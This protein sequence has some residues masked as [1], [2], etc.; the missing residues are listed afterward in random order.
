MGFFDF[1]FG[2]KKSKVTVEFH[3]NIARSEQKPTKKVDTTTQDLVLLCVAEEYRINETKY[4]DSLRTRFG[5]GF[6]KEKFQQL[7]NNGYL[8]VST[9]VET[10]PCLKATE[11]KAIAT[12][13]GV[14]TSGKK[15][16]ICARIAEN[17][18]EDVLQSEIIERYWILTE[19]GKLYLEEHA[20]IR[21][22]MEKHPYSLENIGLDINAYSKLFSGNPIGQVRD[23]LW[24][25]FN[26]LSEK[27]FIEG[28]NQKSF[29]N[30]CDLLRTMALFLEEENRHKD[31]LAMYIRYLHYRAN[32]DAG[33]SVVRNYSIMK[34]IK[35]TADMLYMDV[36][37][38]PFIASEIRDMSNGCGFDSQQL[39]SFMNDQLAKEK[40]TGVFSPKELAA[41]VMCGLN[42]D[43]EGQ[44]K[45][46]LT[47]VKSIARKIPTKR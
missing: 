27:Y 44:K 26:R 39:H 12:K 42:G 28:V 24:G 1:L 21:F 9:A 25:E 47:A 8:R 20:Y 30:Y 34:D 7:A 37:I 38:L 10:L 6:P 14:K 32:F 13:L 19:K 33:V 3:G 40:D 46:C 16:D 11:L 22:F 23:V 45:I 18:S 41:L 5:I 31:A 4:P 43:Q 36:E 2:K 29:R 15:S 17:S 35:H